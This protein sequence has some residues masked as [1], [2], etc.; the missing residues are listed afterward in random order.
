MAE[1]S[2][3]SKAGIIVALALLFAGS[4]GF[5]I[6]QYIQSTKTIEAQATTIQEKETEIEEQSSQIKKQLTQIDSI[7]DALDVVRQEKEALGLDVS[8]LEEQITQLQADRDYYAR[9]FIKPSERKRLE[10]T[11]ANYKALLQDQENKLQQITATRDSLFSENTSLKQDIVSIHDTINLLEGI[12]EKQEKRIE[13]GS[14]LFASDSKVTAIKNLEKG[15]EKYDENQEYRAKDMLHS[16]IEFQILPNNTAET[17][18][19]DVF[20]QVIAS[21]KEV[22]HD[23]Q[24]GSGNFIVD[25]EEKVYTVAQTIFYRSGEYNDVSLVFSNPD[26]LMKGLYQIKV[27]CEGIVIGT[28]EFKIK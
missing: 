12:N 22:V 4:A 28:G 17:G 10:N 5:N 20:V 16:K 23:M 6:Y 13:K 11:I 24:N 1:Q 15:K 3:S 9:N 21:N 19:K 8:A 25:D 14:K 26:E 2:K 27:W 18:N 7:A